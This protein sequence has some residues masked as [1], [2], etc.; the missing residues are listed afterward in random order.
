MQDLENEQRPIQDVNH[1][2]AVLQ[3]MWSDPSGPDA[4]MKSGV[5]MSHRGEDIP[6]FGPDVSEKYCRDNKLGMI[7]RSHQY[8]KEGYKVSKPPAPRTIERSSPM[9]VF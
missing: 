4:D 1:S 7:I 8:I 6:E 2:T 3:A 9:P 5:H